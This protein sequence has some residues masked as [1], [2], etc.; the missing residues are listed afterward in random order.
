MFVGG[1]KVCAWADLIQGA[2]LI[3]AG[4]IIT[5]LVFLALGQA[6]PRPSPPR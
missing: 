3:L 5:Y 1:L 2:S 6:D 4:V